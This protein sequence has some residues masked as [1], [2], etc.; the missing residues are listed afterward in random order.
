MVN[1]KLTED[2]IML[3]EIQISFIKINMN[4]IL[5]MFLTNLNSFN[6]ENNTEMY[7]KCI[8]SI[9][10]IPLALTTLATM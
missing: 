3:V 1:P 7:S 5:A 9:L 8:I 6:Y 2:K 4:N 10:N